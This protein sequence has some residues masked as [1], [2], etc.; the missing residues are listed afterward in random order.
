[1]GYIKV[2]KTMQG[3]IPKP[4]TKYI[5]VGSSVGLGHPIMS[6]MSISKTEN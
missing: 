4:V 1:M 5:I 6:T 2:Q 3:I